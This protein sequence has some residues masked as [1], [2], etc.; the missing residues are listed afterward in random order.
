LPAAGTAGAGA[1]NFVTDANAATFNTVVAAGG[2]NKV[3]VFSDGT[4][5]RIG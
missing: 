2:S 5:W 4:S 1:R 3:P